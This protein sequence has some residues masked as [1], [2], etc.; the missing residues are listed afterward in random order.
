MLGREIKPGMMLA[1]FGLII[2]VDHSNDDKFWE[3]PH[4]WFIPIEDPYHGRCGTSIKLDD[5]YDELFPIGSEGYKLELTRMMVELQECIED[6]VQDIAVI[7]ERMSD[8]Q[9]TRLH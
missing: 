7:E 2:E 4:I 6:K 1:R 9:S 5:E 3:G 8:E